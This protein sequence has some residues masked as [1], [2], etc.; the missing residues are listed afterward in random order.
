M[1][2]FALFPYSPTCRL[3]SPPGHR[4]SSRLA[5]AL[6]AEWQRIND[7][8][9]VALAMHRWQLASVP[10]C[11]SPDEL[12]DR[13]GRDR[14]ISESEADVVLAELIEH[15][16]T[17]EIAARV[18]LQRVLPGLVNVAKRRGGVFEREREF[19]FN[20]VVATAWIVIREYPI[21]R[22]PR[23]IASNVV[24]DAE[25][26]A[27][28]RHARLRSATEESHGEDSMPLTAAGTSGRSVD[29]PPSSFELVVEVLAEAKRRG[30]PHD[31]LLL[32]VG[33]AS[34]RAISSIAADLGV[35]PRTVLNRKPAVVAR[36]RDLE[37]ELEEAA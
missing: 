9:Q 3:S 15:A 2:D 7:R 29:Q 25:Y 37:R 20:D 26:F 33:L 35:T 21:D 12:L 23:R 6:T 32:A 24:R 36:I 28:V 8:G 14:T 1:T 18:V 27:F 31:D 10:V 13:L 16:R 30:L 19:A 17:D 5:S 22:R 4:L 34:G 11:S